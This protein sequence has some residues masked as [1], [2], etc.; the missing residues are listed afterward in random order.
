M[1]IALEGIDGAGKGTQAR[2][3]V[4]WLR[5]RGYRVHLTGEPTSGEIGRLLRRMLVS[6]ELLSRTEALLFAADRSE[7]LR[8]IEGRLAAGEVVV[9]D[10]YVYSS[11]AYQS[12]SGLELE[13]VR[14]INSFAPEAELVLYLD[15]PPQVALERLGDRRRDRYER[16]E[17]LERVRRAYLELAK[18][19][20]FELID[21][22]R[23]VEEVHAEVVRVVSRRLGGR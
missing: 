3:L 4:E 16:V 8:E 18:G 9:T 1:L 23:G 6:G 14:Q 13:W 7:H 10:R 2:L 20:N 21:A 22:S 12:A 5:G 19:E 17:F 11:L 15:L